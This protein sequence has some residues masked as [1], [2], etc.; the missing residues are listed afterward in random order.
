MMIKTW[1]NGAKGKDVRDIINYNFNIVSEALNK[2]TQDIDSA[3]WIVNT[4]SIPFSVHGVKTP[5]VQL[6]IK[7]GSSFSPVLGGVNVDSEY[8]VTLSTDLP[9]RGKVII[10]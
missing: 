7:D 10:K 5:T 2:Y 6:L 1:K 8:N 9:F 4:I 3:D